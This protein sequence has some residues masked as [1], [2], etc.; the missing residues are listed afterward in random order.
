MSDQGNPSTKRTK[1]TPRNITAPVK[2]GKLGPAKAFKEAFRVPWKQPDLNPLPNA[3]PPAS[4]S[5]PIEQQPA[6][7]EVIDID[8]LFDDDPRPSP[9]PPNLST[10]EP[11]ERPDS[12][13]FQEPDFW[14]DGG[15]E[16]SN[17][18]ASHAPPAIKLIIKFYSGCRWRRR[19]VPGCCGGIEGLGN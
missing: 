16:S 4:S 13:P 3:S 19:V 6:P 2:L 14:S 1:I 8:A 5:K 17:Y 9:N 11:S 18:S 10:P 15:I 12:P 7:A